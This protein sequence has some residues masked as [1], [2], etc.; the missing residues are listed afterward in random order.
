MKTV[1]EGLLAR[2]DTAFDVVAGVEAR[3]FIFTGAVATIAGTG[4]SPIRKQGKLPELA[5]QIS[6][7][8]EHCTDTLEVSPDQESG[9]QVLLIDD[10]PATGGAL[11]TRTDHIEQAGSRVTAAGV[12][13]EIEGLGDRELIPQVIGVIHV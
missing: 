8:E 12:I 5:H 9:M 13:M 7:R 2:T 6:Y 11:R 1:A 4:M 3:G 10:I